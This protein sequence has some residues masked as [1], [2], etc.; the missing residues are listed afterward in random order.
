MSDDCVVKRN[1]KIEPFS[2]DKILARVKKLGKGELRVN[3]TALVQKIID[4]LYDGIPTSYIDELTAQQ[5]ASLIT[6]HQDY[7]ILASRIMISNHHK[8]TSASFKQVIKELYMFKDV[9]GIHH[10]LIAKEMWEL[11]MENTEKIEKMIDYERDYYIDF[12]GFKTLE[13]AYLMKINGI[14]KERPQHMWMRVA[15]SIHKNNWRK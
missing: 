10:P 12:F 3:D 13:R 4:R 2:F 1:G 15:L 8:N 14:I 9:H 6:T 7:G 11:V 5:C